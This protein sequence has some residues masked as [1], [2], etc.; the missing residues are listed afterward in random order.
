MAGDRG[1]DRGAVCLGGQGSHR[2][3]ARA[4]GR[5][6]RQVQSLSAASRTVDHPYCVSAS[7]RDGAR[8][9]VPGIDPLS[10][11][12]PDTVLATL[13]LSVG[14]TV[15]AVGVKTYKNQ[16]RAAFVAAGKPVDRQLSQIFMVE[17]GPF[18]DESVDVTKLQ[19]FL[20]TLFLAGT[21]TL[22]TIHT[23]A[24]AEPGTPIH[25]PAGI[26]ALPAFDATFLGLL[27]IS[28]AGYLAGNLPSRG[29]TIP[30]GTFPP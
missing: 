5:H 12:I 8:A 9:T 29:N 6:L 24:G 15:L 1:S 4:I 30:P 2:L 17:E 27:A 11:S 26:A 3:C 20:I 22:I 14:S 25:T 19:N 28:H 21:Y 13:G 10:F 23:F 7:W 16:K 18:A